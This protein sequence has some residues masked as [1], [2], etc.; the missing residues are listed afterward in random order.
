MIDRYISD[1]RPSSVT[2]YLDK[3]VLTAVDLTELTE[4]GGAS[5]ITSCADDVACDCIIALAGGDNEWEND[6]ADFLYKVPFDNGE[7]INIDLFLEKDGVEVHEFGDADPDI[8]DYYDL[9]SFTEEAG[10]ELYKGIV[11]KWAG[12]L[13]EYGAGKYR[14]RSEVSL[15]EATPVIEYSECFQLYQYHCDIAD[16]TV[17]FEWLQNGELK[18][19]KFNYKGMEWRRYRRV[20]GKIVK[21][22]PTLEKDSILYTNYFDKQVQDSLQN[23]Y[24]FESGTLYF[25]T[26]K[27]LVYDMM[28]ADEIFITDYNI[29]SHRNDYV[30]MPVRQEEI[31]D[32]SEFAGSKKAVLNLTFSD[33]IKNHI[34][35]S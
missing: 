8:N 17:Y 6:K 35:N 31:G 29:S 26:V 28:L 12:V 5:T 18:S 32:L 22:T 16:G 14:V 11:V 15:G 25:A 1:I 9:G 3:E 13:T 27:P 19:S 33:R 2:G 10:Q 4:P 24:Q 30:M 20:Q 7:E 23:K 21:W 34:K